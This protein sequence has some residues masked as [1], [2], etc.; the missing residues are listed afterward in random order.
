MPAP[1][2]ASLGDRIAL[3]KQ[4]LPAHVKLI[5]VTKQV[6]IAQMR[7]AYGAGL[8]D[9]AENRVLEAVTKRQQLADLSDLTW[10]FIGHL[11]SNKAAIALETFDWL[12]SIDSLK[13][14]QKLNQLSTHRVHKPNLLLQVK[15]WPDPDK[16]GWSIP[17]LIQDLPQLADCDRLSIQGLMTILPLGLDPAQQLAIFQQVQQ[18]ACQI[19]QQ[20]PRLPIPELSMGMSQ[21]YPLAI[22]A[23]ATMIRLGRIIFGN[24]IHP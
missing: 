15:G 8:R 1:L 20:Y 7:Q 12:H 10:H 24:P 11:Q 2:P 4:S 14:A 22:Q 13:L 6:D 17:E 21:D 3:L 16:F 5:A 9:F 18:L 19:R 23:G